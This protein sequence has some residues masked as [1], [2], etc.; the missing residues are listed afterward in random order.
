VLDVC[1]A[2]GINAALL[3]ADVTLAQLYERYAGVG[4]ACRV[5]LLDRG[6]AED[7]EARDPSDGLAAELADLDLVLTTRGVGYIGE[8]TCDRLLRPSAGRS[9]P[10]GARPRPGRPGAGRVVPRLP[11]LSRPAE[12][13]ERLPL[14][15]LLVGVV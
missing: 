12:D 2:Y 9:R 15:D 11:Y 1:C 6:W 7:L 8:R 13:V 5:G 10:G 3:R 4:F 14:R